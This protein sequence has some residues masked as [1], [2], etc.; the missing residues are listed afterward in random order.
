MLLGIAMIAYWA[1]FVLRGNM[2]QG[3]WTMQNN[4]Y[5]ALHIGAEGLTALLALLGGIGLL[6]GRGWGM[7][8][9][10]VALGGL[11]YTSINSLAYS[12]ATE[13]TLTTVFLTVLA[14]VL[15][16]FIALHWSRRY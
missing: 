1:D 12:L 3:L 13:P 9:A 2:P 7:A 6:V 8:T 4:Q 15:L 16:S 5:L 14:T 11:L 10:L